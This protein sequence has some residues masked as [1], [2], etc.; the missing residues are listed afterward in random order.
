MT[1]VWKYNEESRL[2]IGT[3]LD[4]A[5]ICSRATLHFRQNLPFTRPWSTQSCST[6]VRRGCWP[7]GRRTNFSYLRESF[8]ERYAKIENGVTGGGTTTNSIKRQP[9][10]PKCH[11][12]KNHMI[13][14]PKDLLQ[15]ALFRAKPNVRRNQGRPK[16]RWADGVEQR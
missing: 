3:S 13:R 5:C 16:S 6:A 4:C 12:D 15:K 9:E 8:S 11:E 2:Q 7:K 10:C 1:W 14:R